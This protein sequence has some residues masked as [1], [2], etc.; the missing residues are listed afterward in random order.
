[1]GSINFNNSTQTE[2][3]DINKKVNLSENKTNVVF[4]LADDMGA[5]AMRNAGNHDVITPGLD[6][7]AQ[8]GCK[9][10]NFYCA[11]PV[12]SPARAS[13][14]T[15][16]MPSTHGVYDWIRS[17]SVDKSTLPEDLKTHPYY[18]SEDKPIQYLAEFETYTE[19]LAQNGYDCRLSGKWH[20]GDSV[21]VDKGFSKVFTIARGGCWYHKADV[22]QDGKIH[23]DDRYITDLI[24]EDALKNIDEQAKEYKESG[25]PFYLSVHFTAPHTPWDEF[26]HPEDVWSMYDDCE[27]S[28][29]PSRDLHQWQLVSS[30]W[31]PPIGKENLD[32]L[33]RAEKGLEVDNEKLNIAKKKYADFE[34]GRKVRLRGYYTAIT[35][36]DRQINRIVDRLEELNVRDN[37][38]IIFMADNGMNL[39]QHGVWGKGNG[40]FPLN[41]YESSCKVPCIFSLPTHLNSEKDIDAITSQLDIFHTLLDICNCP[42]S[43]ENP[44]RPGSS[45]LGLMQRNTESG[46][47]NL[48]K[49]YEE[50]ILSRPAVVVDEYGPN[51]MIRLGNDKLV[52]RYPYGPDELYQLDKDPDEEHNLI[53]D[54]NYQELRYKLE[55]ELTDWCNKHMDPK[56]DGSREA[57]TGFGQ[58]SRAGHNAK[59]KP[60]FADQDK[61]RVNFHID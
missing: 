34:E 40:T 54:P 60:A 39:G 57:V 37:T 10:S 25:K 17:G 22:V 28:A 23:I 44:Y 53:H 26:D 27:F 20:L 59:S 58:L 33:D 56:M 52:K 13:I 19:I 15:G 29:T 14:M 47:A 45:L 49:S 24:A 31:P 11:S 1:M 61:V 35:A 48:S 18:A 42:P 50:S 32:I 46:S 5:W 16:M 30:E 43:T 12:C 21:N 55:N 3:N 4:I 41:L 6:R 7:L 9:F 38:L 8:E 51:R 2:N 36:M